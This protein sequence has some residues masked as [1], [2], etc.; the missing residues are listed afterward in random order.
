MITAAER[1]DQVALRT[2]DD[3]AVA[4][5]RGTPW[6]ASR[7]SAAGLHGAR[8][9]ARRHGRPDAAQPARVP[10]LRRRGDAC[11]ARCPFASTTPRPAEADRLRDGR[12]RQPRRRHR[13]AVRRAI[14]AAKGRRSRRASSSG[15]THVGSATSSR[16]RE[17]FDFEATWRAVEPS[18]LLTLIY[19]SGTT[20]P[21]KGVEL[22]HANMLAELRGVHDV[23]PTGERR[24]P[25]LVPARGP[26]RRPL[27]V[28]LHRVHDLRQHRDA[29]RRPAHVMGRRR[30]GPSDRC[31]GASRASGRSSRPA[32]RRTGVDERRHA[33]RRC[34]RAQ[35]GLDER[36]VVR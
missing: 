25:G 32:S 35:L 15:S 27:G 28:A 10:P 29:G 17:D 5:L 16:R 2:P 34:V 26:H 30:P 8:R 7:R 31:F 14:G 11:S 21:P 19:T 18:D 36:R 20:G 23:L 6:S 3:A 22:T 4:D 9:A 13:A 33:R 24:A 1:P 12:R